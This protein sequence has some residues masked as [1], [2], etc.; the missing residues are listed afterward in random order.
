M[1]KYNIIK[2][3]NKGS[4][5]KVYLIEE[6]SSKDK[7]ALKRI[8]ITGLDRYSIKSIY[9]EINILAL[10][11]C[12]YL[13]KLKDLFVYNNTYLCIIT[14][15]YSNGDLGKY[16]KK[17][18][19]LS[20]EN[21][22]KI[23]TQLCVALNYL[24]KNN[25]IHR[26][27]KPGNILIDNNFNICLCDFGV[28]KK[29]TSKITNTFIGTPLFMSPEQISN[30]YYD[31]KIDIWSLGC[32]L[33]ELEYCKPPFDGKSLRSLKEKILYSKLEGFNSGKFGELFSKL[34]IRDKYKRPTIND[35]LNLPIIK[36]TIEEN[37]IKTN[38]IVME[39]FL[40]YNYIGNIKE[41]KKFGAEYKNLIKDCDCKPKLINEQINN[42]VNQPGADP[43]KIVKYHKDYNP[44]NF[45]VEDYKKKEFKQVPPKTPKKEMPILPIIKK[46]EFKP[47][48]P[49]I[50]KKEMPI[51]PIIN[52]K[53]L[54][55]V[56]PKISKRVIRNKI[57]KAR[58]CQLFGDRNFYNNNNMNWINNLRKY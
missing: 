43:P 36:Y 44:I 21:I 39:S 30:R 57:P 32:V 58:N 31:I 22:L 5:G 23:F 24:H 16:C 8:R 15:Y 42:Y 51:L 6:K 33:Y 19:K 3:I 46:K 49:K 47:V 41:W 53:E 26:D 13:L 7:Y 18:N 1:D 38:V 55:P 35:V 50:L 2:F 45:K 10:N 37:D 27:I 52:K 17:N 12:P 25:I 11:R 14:E 40:K 54:K 48:P 9:N 4:F 56:P 34:F 29:M 20:E 28:S